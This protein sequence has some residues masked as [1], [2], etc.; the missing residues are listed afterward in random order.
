MWRPDDFT[1]TALSKLVR[2][3]HGSLPWARRPSGVERASL[4]D[5]ILVNYWF[6]MTIMG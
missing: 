5:K 1:H 2:V 3:D 4:E 6:P